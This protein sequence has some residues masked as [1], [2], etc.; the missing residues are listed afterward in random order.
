MTK[1]DDNDDR[2]NRIGRIH[3]I[4]QED[5]ERI[6]S[7]DDPLVVLN[8]KSGAEMDQVNSRYERYERFYRAENFQR[9]GDME[10]TRKALDIRR[11]IGRAMVEIQTIG[12]TGSSNVLPVTDEVP[13]LPP[14]DADSAAFGDV[15]YRDGLTFMRL[16]DF[17]GAFD[18]FQRA[19]D[20]DPSR[21][22]IIA[23]L[24]YTH[25]KRRSNDP[26]LIDDTNNSLHRAARLEPGNAEI[27]VLLARFAI[28]CEKAELAREAIARIEDLQPSHPRLSKLRERARD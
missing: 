23:N 12:N 4:V 20:F 17:D 21:G 19:S 10:L 13:A 14:V 1:I 16:G 25:F 6:C 9:L 3:T 11:A 28:N 26:S 22:I 18:C 5:Y 24:A 2:V 8:L 7:T 15:Y 27:F